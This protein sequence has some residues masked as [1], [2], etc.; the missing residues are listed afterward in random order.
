MLAINPCSSFL[1]L[2]NS[3]VI[4]WL[5]LRAPTTGGRS[6]IPGWGIKIPKATKHGQM[7]KQQIFYS[8]VVEL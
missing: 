4:Q 5:G 2:G 1:F 3:L 7:N 6:L 8:L